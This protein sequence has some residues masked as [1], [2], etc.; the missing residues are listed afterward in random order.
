MKM[1]SNIVSA[2]KREYKRVCYYTNWAQY[3][4]E[5]GK[6]MPENIQLDLCTHL[7]YAYASLEQNE[8]KTLAGND[9]QM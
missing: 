2:G 1:I 7:I 4:P 9:L 3:R 8:I 5:G 6:F